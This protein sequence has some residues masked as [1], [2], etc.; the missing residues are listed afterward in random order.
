M[1]HNITYT[2]G[3][4]GRFWFALCDRNGKV[5]DWTQSNSESVARLFFMA[6]RTR[7]IPAYYTVEKRG[8]V[9]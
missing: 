9:A 3:H 8:K 1:S 4:T 5:R 2:K 6:S 7:Q